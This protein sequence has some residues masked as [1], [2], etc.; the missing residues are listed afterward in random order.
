MLAIRRRPGGDY[1]V[2]ISLVRVGAVIEERVQ[3]PV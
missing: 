1:I 3:R 2:A